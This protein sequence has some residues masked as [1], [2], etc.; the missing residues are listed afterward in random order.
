MARKL[1]HGSSAHELLCANFLAMR[2]TWNGLNRAL[3]N[4]QLLALT[5]AFSGQYMKK[6]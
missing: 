6:A 5:L 3:E 4:N 1:A 2:V